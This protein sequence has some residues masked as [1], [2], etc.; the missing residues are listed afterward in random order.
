ML[1]CGKTWE[2][3]PNKGTG[4]QLSKTLQGPLKPYSEFIDRLSHFWGCELS[5]ASP[6]V[7][8]LLKILTNTVK[9]LY[10]PIKIKN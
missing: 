8:G 7:I 1:S 5:Y 2:A 4:E 9:R 10:T 6:K 3:L